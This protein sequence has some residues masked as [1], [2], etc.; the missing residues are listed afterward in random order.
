MSAG[1]RAVTGM[2]GPATA[3]SPVQRVKVDGSFDENILQPY[4]EAN[5][6]T[7]ALTP[8]KYSQDVH[9]DLADRGRRSTWW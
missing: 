5:K 4:D 6:K 3:A 7:K 1:N 8:H 2:I 9:Y